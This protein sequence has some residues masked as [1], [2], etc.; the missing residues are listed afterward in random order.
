[1]SIINI[2]NQIKGV[3]ML[4]VYQNSFIG[5]WLIVATIIVQAMVA[6][7]VHRRQEGGYLPGVLKPSHLIIPLLFLELIGLFKTHWKI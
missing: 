2:N 3:G 4:E 5:L 7:R 6:V 1:M